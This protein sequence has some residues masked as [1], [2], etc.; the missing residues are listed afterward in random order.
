MT[1]SFYEVAYGAL[2]FANPVTLEMVDR[3]LAPARLEAGGR[4]AD[5]GCGAGAM[6]FHLAETHGQHV[7][8]VD[9]S[10]YM[11]GRVRARVEAPP[12]AGSVTPHLL[13]AEDYLASAEPVDLIV[14]LAATEF[15]TAA[16]TRQALFSQLTRALRPGGHLL[17]GDNFWRRPPSP[18]LAAVTVPYDSL[19]QYLLA[20]EA[21]GLEPRSVV[22]SDQGA[23]DEYAWS[24]ARS[25]AD[26]AR[27][28]PDDPRRETWSHQ[29]RALLHAYL[30]E[31][32]DRMGFA[33]QLFRAP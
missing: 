7:D 21:A 20:G 5:L 13:R 27:A 8:A 29:G 18:E 2:P 11:I 10:E 4:A 26:W 32:R 24:M 28:N 14:V 6:A 31:A 9:A 17:Y 25:L 22:E 3:V 16:G 33:L 30:G 15:V 19:H 12:R 1:E 23:W